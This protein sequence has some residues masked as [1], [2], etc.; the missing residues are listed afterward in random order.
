MAVN[1]IKSPKEQIFVK[2]A[3]KAVTE[4]YKNPENQ[5]KFKTWYQEKNG[6]PWQHQ[7]YSNTVEG[8]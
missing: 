7:F 6:V 5:E 1:K 3:A 2:A 4:F 8:V